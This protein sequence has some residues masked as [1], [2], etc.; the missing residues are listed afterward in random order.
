MPRCLCI[1]KTTNLQCGKFAIKGSLFCSEHQK[2]LFTVRLPKKSLTAKEKARIVSQVKT[3]LAEIETVSGKKNKIL[4]SMQ[5]YDI[6]T[7]PLGLLFIDDNENFKKTV[8][9]KLIE[10]IE[11]EQLPRFIPY[12]EK[13]F[14][15]Y[16][17]PTINQRQKISHEMSSPR[18]FPSN[19]PVE[20]FRQFFQ[21]FDYN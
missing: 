2:C 3:K 11:I 4:I 5:M 15:K 13:I 20:E 8:K 10:F 1:A 17:P 7:T 16:I 14:G 6:L 12:Y 19:S 18:E 9:N 21:K